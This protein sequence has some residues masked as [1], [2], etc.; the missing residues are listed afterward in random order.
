MATSLWYVDNGA[1]Y[2]VMGNTN[3]FNE[4]IEKDMQF[5]IEMGDDGKYRA[6]GIGIVR[7]ERESGNPLFLKDVLYVPG[8]KKSVIS[9]STLEDN[10]YEVT[11]RLCR[12]FIKPS[13]TKVS[14]SKLGS[15]I[16]TCTNCS[17]RQPRH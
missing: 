2:H 17:L 14:I 13:D 8:L 6:K 5:H 7:F 16:R 9:I 4:L 3:Y 1:S 12:V 15:D 11:F 10:V